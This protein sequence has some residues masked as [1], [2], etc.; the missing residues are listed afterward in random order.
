MFSSISNYFSSLNS[1]GQALFIVGVLLIITFIVFLIVV[2]KP[3]KKQVKIYGENPLTD[4]ENQVLEKL[5]DIDN[6]SE[7]DINLENDKT[8]NLKTIVDELKNVDSK[9]NESMDIIE[10][11][12]DEQENTAVISV[13]E[14]LRA[15]ENYSVKEPIIS[16]NKSTENVDN[17][18]KEIPDNNEEKIDS[19]L[20]NEPI[21]TNKKEV[22]FNAPITP[23]EPIKNT[24]YENK[25]TPSPEI[26]SSV[27]TNNTRPEEKK[28]EENNDDNEKFLNSLKEFRNN[29]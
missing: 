22:L 12:E 11:Y 18:I 17:S 20:F 15:T 24:A 1:A 6:I 27:F 25:Y 23:P 14:L 5:K 28:I 4:K 7:Y 10:R 2:L 3:E 9:E 21:I 29:L 13:N 8:K 26:F 16:E 19:F